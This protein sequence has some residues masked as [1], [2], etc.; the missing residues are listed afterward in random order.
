MNYGNMMTMI[1]SLLLLLVILVNM[2]L[3]LSILS[4]GGTGQTFSDVDHD[5]TA[6]YDVVII[7]AGWAGLA[8]A[9]RLRDKGVTN[10]KILEARDYIGGRCRTLEGYFVD[11]LATEAGASWVYRNSDIDD[12]Y[13]K[14]ALQ[15]DVSRFNFDN[16]KLYNDFGELSKTESKKMKK[17]YIHGFVAYAEEY[18]YSGADLSVEELIDSYFNSSQGR[19][20]PN[21]RR[22]AVNAFVTPVSTNLGQINGEADAS[23]IVFDLT[24][25]EK[26]DFTA[27]P[28]GGFTPVI[29]EYAKPIADWITLGSVVT[30][31]NYT[32][33]VVEVTTN[34]GPGMNSIYR[35]RTV[36]CTVPIGVLQHR[37]I[38]FVPDLP[39]KKWNAIDNI[40]NGSVNKCIMYWDSSKKD[41]SWWPKGELELQL[42]TSDDMGSNAWTYFLNDQSHTINNDHYVLTAW[43][44]GH[45]VE[46]LEA[47]NDDQTLARVLVN[48]RTMF[49]EEVPTPTKILITRWLSDPYSRGVHTFRETGVN[50]DHAK[51]ELKRS[52]DDKLFFAGEATDWG[53]NTVTAYTSGITVA[54]DVGRRLKKK[55]GTY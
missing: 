1:P 11:G 19:S 14:L 50:D 12:L 52:L 23:N 30:K 6:L 5:N 53:S 32:D 49:G 7:G 15:W 46:E 45:I 20:L 21:M 25:N 40:G 17:Q 54:N 29:N 44:A 2:L 3:I 22:Q 9:N 24:W 26:L 33:N 4:I 41:I 35:T 37:D 38:Q 51:K 39:E 16:I 28:Y 48:L 36:I 27:V 10:V 43:S 42:I 34:N 13:D 47:E 8:A 31:I 18:A 55:N